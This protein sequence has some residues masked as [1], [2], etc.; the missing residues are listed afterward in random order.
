MIKLDLEITNIGVYAKRHIDTFNENK[1]IGYS[2]SLEAT[3]CVGGSNSSGIYFCDMA[4]ITLFDI[5][6]EFFTNIKKNVHTSYI[7]DEP[8][9]GAKEVVIEAGYAKVGG[10]LAKLCSDHLAGI[11]YL[12][13]GEMNE[14]DKKRT[15]LTFY[16]KF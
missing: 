9:D 6:K 13:S 11:C 16:F 4:L 12:L 8:F 5:D 1:W 15:E 10:K 7:S 3:G 2:N 14:E